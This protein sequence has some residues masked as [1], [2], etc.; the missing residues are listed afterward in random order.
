MTNR[1]RRLQELNWKI[2][3]NIATSAE[4]LEYMEILHQEGKITDEQLDA[5]RRGKNSDAI[6]KTAMV[7]GGALLVLWILNELL[8]K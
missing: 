3:N 5:Y 6:L 8:K 1:K 4:K 7:I 2:N